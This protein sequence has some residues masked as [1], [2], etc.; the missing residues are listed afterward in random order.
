MIFDLDAF[1]SIVVNL[2]AFIFRSPLNASIKSKFKEQEANSNASSPLQLKNIAM[3]IDPTYTRRNVQSPAS[4]DTTSSSTLT[5]TLSSSPGILPSPD[6]SDDG[7]LAL[8][9]MPIQGQKRMGSVDK[10]KRRA[11]D[12][13]K[14]Q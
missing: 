11:K 4:C 12:G 1:L 7:D 8:P 5:S 10:K 9:Y 2:R 3:A 13:C 6:I 14:Q